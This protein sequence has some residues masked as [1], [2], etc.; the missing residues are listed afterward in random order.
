LSFAEHP[1]RLFN[2]LTEEWALCFPHRAGCPWHGQ[3]E[4]ST[5]AELPSH[6]PDCCLRPGNKRAGCEKNPVYSS[7]FPFSMGWQA[8][9]TDGES[10]PYWRLHAVYYPPLL[11]SAT[12]KKFMVVYEMAAEPQR[13]FTPE[14]AALRL[15][16][17]SEIH[18]SE[19]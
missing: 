18:F 7:T 14:R 1:R 11:R 5:A 19:K 13:D 4:R 16:E 9:P 8:C 3:L 12:V 15:K 2:P 10:H 6:D 17:M